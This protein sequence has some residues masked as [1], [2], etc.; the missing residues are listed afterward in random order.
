VENKKEVLNFA[1]HQYNSES[2]TEAGRDVV[3][4]LDA[5]RM[6]EDVTWEIIQRKFVLMGVVYKVIL[7]FI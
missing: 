5:E 1:R 7:Y 4:L 3:R 2:R 6:S